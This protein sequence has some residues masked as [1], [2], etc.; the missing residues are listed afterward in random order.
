MENRE[1]EHGQQRELTRL[2]H[3]WQGG[4]AAAR[5]QLMPLVYDTLHRLAD[6]Q[7]ARERPDHTLQPTALIHEAFLNLDRSRIAWQDRQHFYAMVA[8]TMR[9]V[10]VD[11]AR[12][13]LRQKRGGDRLRVDLSGD[14]IPAPAADADLLALDHAL[15]RLA[16]RSERIS[17]VL[18][19]IYFGGLTRSDVADL[20]NTSPRTV[21]RDLSLG[22]AWLRRELDGSA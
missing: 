7:F 6:Q 8:S 12:A 10:L 16:G 19:L 15:S 3:Q 13:R 18:E 9:H 2:L 21:D 14:E 17:R 4:D 20:T 11:H 1:R 22:R 5:D